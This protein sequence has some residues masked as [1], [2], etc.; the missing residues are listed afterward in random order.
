MNNITFLIINLLT[1]AVVSLIVTYA[2][3]EIFISGQ[4]NNLISVDNEN[5]TVSSTEESVSDEIPV[6]TQNSDDSPPIL[7]R[8]RT[9]SEQYFKVETELQ[10]LYA[11]AEQYDNGNEDFKLPS[12]LENQIQTLEAELDRLFEEL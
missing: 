12:E 1:A 3:F 6:Y 10:E 11:Q 5:Q 4:L 8:T 9:I 7:E 2:M